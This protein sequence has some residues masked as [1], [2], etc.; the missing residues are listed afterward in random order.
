MK[1]EIY[2]EEHKANTGNVGFVKVSEPNYK[3]KL[4]SEASYSQ[5]YRC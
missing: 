1:Q 3:R 5:E 2:D 4:L